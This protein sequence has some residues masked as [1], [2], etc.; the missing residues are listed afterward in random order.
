MVRLTVVNI[1]GILSLYNIKAP[2]KRWST[3]SEKGGQHHRN[4]WSRWIGIYNQK[5]TF[6]V[7]LL[8]G[9]FKSTGCD[10]K[11]KVFEVRKWKK[12]FKE[13]NIQLLH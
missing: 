7:N 9:L 11:G 4:R 6:K 2:L 10:Q 13:Q 3:S 8:G 5:K 12:I 1:T